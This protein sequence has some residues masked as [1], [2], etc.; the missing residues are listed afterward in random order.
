MFSKPRQ[1][2]TGPRSNDGHWVFFLQLPSTCA[3][4]AS[5]SAIASGVWFYKHQQQARRCCFPSFIIASSAFIV[6]PGTMRRGLFPQLS[7]R[8]SAIADETMAPAAFHNLTTDSSSVDAATASLGHR[9]FCTYA[10]WLLRFRRLLRGCFA[11]CSSAI[12]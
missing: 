11:C 10:S 5:L 7:L 9:G 6:F 1:L 8:T 3:T 2:A 12:R 4:P